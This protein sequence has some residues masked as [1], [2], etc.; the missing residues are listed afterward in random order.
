MNCFNYLILLILWLSGP[1]ETPSTPWGEDEYVKVA[2]INSNQKGMLSLT[3]EVKQGFSIMAH[4]LKNDNFLP[5]EILM[6]RNKVVQFG[7]ATFS[8]SH[9]K[10]LNGSSEPVQ[11]FSGNFTVNIPYSV[12]TT[13]DVGVYALEG[14]FFYQTCDDHKCYFPRELAFEVNYSIE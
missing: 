2:Q 8:A 11:V 5:A 7:K 13:N 3:F 6:K 4:E 10:Y 14:L 12:T 1:S 9:K